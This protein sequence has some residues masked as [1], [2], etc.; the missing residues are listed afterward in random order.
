VIRIIILPKLRPP[1]ATPS[2]IEKVLRELHRL[3]R[4]FDERLPSTAKVYNDGSSTRS[5]GVHR[6]TAREERR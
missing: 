6:P 3:G 1:A 4:K 5:A 2:Q